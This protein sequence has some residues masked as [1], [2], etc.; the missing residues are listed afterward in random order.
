LV[1]LILDAET[2]GQ[3]VK[4]CPILNFS[5]CTFDRSRFVSDEPYT[6][7]ELLG[8]TWQLKLDVATQ[9]RDGYKIEPGTIAFWETVGP[10]ARKQLTPTQNDLTYDQFCST[11]MNR[12]RNEQID[13]WWSRSNTFDPIL[14]WRIFNDAGR[15]EEL[16]EKLKFWRV[17]DV[18]T[19]IDA[20]T[21]F[22]LK[23]NGFA[24]M[25]QDVWDRT[26][27]EHDSRHDVSADVLRMQYLSRMTY[28]EE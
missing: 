14:I 27:K 24:P 5:F 23:K 19:Y 15:S 7:D 10:E 20:I 16:N 2:L 22:K 3:D 6:F 13:Y 1:E 11:M 12:L 8:M 18:R 28:T 4:T 9:V 17:R 26:F 25:A 21:D